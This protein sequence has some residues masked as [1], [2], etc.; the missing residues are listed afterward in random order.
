M[1]YGLPNQE[2]MNKHAKERCEMERMSIPTIGEYMEETLQVPL[3]RR[4]IYWLR[5]QSQKRM[6]AAEQCMSDIK[7]SPAKH[8]KGWQEYLFH[9]Q[10]TDHLMG[11]MLDEEEALQQRREDAAKLAQL[12]ESQQRKASEVLINLKKIASL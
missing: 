9:R 1:K 12:L 5:K 6:M 3:T 8:S 2:S 10:L 11:V 7:A 4:E